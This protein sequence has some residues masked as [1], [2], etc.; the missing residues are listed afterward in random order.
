MD[1]HFIVSN[2]PFQ[3]FVNEFVFRLPSS[4]L[5]SIS[6]PLDFIRYDPPR[7]LDRPYAGLLS[8]LR[9][10]SGSYTCTSGSMVPR[11]DSSSRVRRCRYNGNWFF[12]LFVEFFRF[13]LFFNPCSELDVFFLPVDDT[14]RPILPLPIDQPRFRSLGLFTSWP[15]HG[16]GD[17]ALELLDMEDRMQFV[18]LL[19]KVKSNVDA[20]VEGL[21]HFERPD[22]SISQLSPAL[23]KLVGSQHDLVADFIFLLSTLLVGPLLLLSPLS[24]HNLSCVLPCRSDVAQQVLCG[25]VS[26][27]RSSASHSYRPLIPPVYS[28]HLVRRLSRR[29]VTVTVVM[30]L[31]Y[32]QPLLPVVARSVGM[33]P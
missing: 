6:L 9:R 2:H 23:G 11:T 10:P 32:G 33:R 25:V 31:H 27:T 8:S 22:P 3:T 12:L 20:V 17:E 21:Y 16:A 5:G 7:F 1:S 24:N 29:F 15:F 4:I 28:V 30:H 13:V 14:K 18:V 19:R 26:E